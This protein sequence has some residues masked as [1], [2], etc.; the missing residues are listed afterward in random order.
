MLNMVVCRVTARLEN[1][2]ITEY[3]KRNIV[4]NSKRLAFTAYVMR[5]FHVCCMNLKVKLTVYDN[6]TASTGD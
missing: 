2:K 6:W 3:I 4:F 5:C 1:V